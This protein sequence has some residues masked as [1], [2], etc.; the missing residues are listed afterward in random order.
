ML[1]DIINEAKVV[2]DGVTNVGKTYAYRRAVNS[3][4]LAIAAFKFVTTGEIRAWEITRESTDSVDRTVGGTMESHQLCVYGYM[5][6]SDANQ[7]E[8]TFQLLI[9]QV[10]AQFNTHRTLNGKALE[11]TPMRARTVKVATLSGILVHYCELTITATEFP[12]DT[13]S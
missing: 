9:E 3:E 13:H 4:A 2:L 1:G 5:G 10:R 6:V 8:E 7:S 12:E 11:T